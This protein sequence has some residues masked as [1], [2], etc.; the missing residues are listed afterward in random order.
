MKIFQITS[1]DIDFYFLANLNRQQQHIQSEEDKQ[2]EIATSMIATSKSLLN[3]AIR[4]N[5]I[6][7]DDKKVCFLLFQ[8]EIFISNSLETWRSRKFNR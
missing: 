3:S 2:H 4:L 8:Y 6:V 1:T 7:K 5:D